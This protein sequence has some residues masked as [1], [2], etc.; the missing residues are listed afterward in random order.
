MTAA[1]L[2][3]AG[4]PVVIRACVGGWS[5]F[6]GAVATGEAATFYDGDPARYVSPDPVPTL[7]ADGWH[8][9]EADR[10]GQTYRVPV[11]P[12]HIEPAA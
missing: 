10:Y 9:V 8:I 5:S 6:L 1:A 3:P 7:A 12:E 4:T 11:K 2:Y